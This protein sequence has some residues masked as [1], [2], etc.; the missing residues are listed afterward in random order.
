MT[1]GYQIVPVGG[2]Y[3]WSVYNGEARERG[4]APSHRQAKHQVQI[5]SD[6]LNLGVVPPAEGI[7]V[8]MAVEWVVKAREAVWRARTEDADLKVAARLSEAI[9]Y[10]DA[11]VKELDA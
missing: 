11:A 9:D 1:S 6:R 7:D 3:S 2:K 4:M 5:A 10:L 8:G